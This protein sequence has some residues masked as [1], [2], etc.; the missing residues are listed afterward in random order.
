[1]SEQST[2]FSDVSG[3]ENPPLSHQERIAAECARIETEESQAA[4]PWHPDV[5]APSGR[6]VKVTPRISVTPDTAS[7]WMRKN[8]PQNRGITRARVNRYSKDMTAGLWLYSGEPV[9]FDENGLLINGQHRL[10]AIIESGV[11]VDLLVVRG[12][13]AKTIGVLDTGKPRNEADLLRMAGHT[14]ATGRHVATARRMLLG[15]GHAQGTSWSEVLTHSELCAFYVRHRKA[16]E[17][18]WSVCPRDRLPAPG[19]AVVGRAWY[20]EE[21]RDELE[22]FG[23][24]LDTGSQDPADSGAV[25]LRKFLDDMRSKRQYGGSPIQLRMYAKTQ[26]ALTAF[27][28]G[29][30]LRSL[31]EATAE[32][33]P[34]PGEKL[35]AKDTGAA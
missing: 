27:L 29:E 10:L 30:P 35:T 25:L 5:E 7:L 21:A 33:F 1:M 12:L 14:E 8:H 16:V 4:L 24:V 28:S 11:T 18:A 19:R 34:L 3:G 9:Q 2:P 32:S 20:R 13:P 17:F 6:G 22:R 26:R 15:F 31:L 23:R